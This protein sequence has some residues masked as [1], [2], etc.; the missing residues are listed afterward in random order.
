[1]GVLRE[2]AGFGEAV[3]EAVEGWESAVQVVQNKLAASVSMDIA[4]DFKR[5]V[6]QQANLCF[7]VIDKI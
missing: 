5:T 7:T 2:M 6:F 4:K 1:L 3:R